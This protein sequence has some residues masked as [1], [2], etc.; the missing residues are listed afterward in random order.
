MPS[1]HGG[2][3][4]D[5]KMPNSIPENE[6]QKA[7][8]IAK[9]AVSNAHEYVDVRSRLA[10]MAIRECEHEL[11][12]LERK[13]DE[14]LPA[15]ITR[16]GEDKAR[17]LI[18][19]LQFITDLERIGD[20]ALWVAHHLPESVTRRDKDV[21][22]EM[23][24]LVEHMLEE[25]YTGFCERSAERARAVFK[26][27]TEIDKLRSRLFRTH[28]KS[29]ARTS[30]EDRIAL[31]LVAQALERAGDHCTNLAEEVI[32][33]VEQ[34]SVRHMP[35]NILSFNRLLETES[36]NVERNANG[37]VAPVNPSFSVDRKTGR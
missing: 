21:L 33:L 12:V 4:R 26:S 35:K 2:A 34:R 16:V 30:V 24:S 23:L 22:L 11:D 13:I 9:D 1:T 6:I 17:E 10:L 25:A 37:R 20:L 28:L 14:N 31:L 36:R 8:L 18:A 3:K 29:S 5:F 7:F 32:H 19:Y 15:A 27:D